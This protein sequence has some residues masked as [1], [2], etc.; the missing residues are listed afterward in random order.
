MGFVVT[1]AAKKLSKLEKKI[2]VIPGGTSAGK[3]YNILPILFSKAA[4]TPNLSISVV[5]ET[6][7][8]LKRGAMRDFLNVIKDTDR[9]HRPFWNK[10]DSLYTLPND[11]FMEFFSADD[12]QRV[13]GPRRDIL[14][15]NEA[16]SLKFD[17]FYQML[18][19]TRK[20]IWLDF[21]PTTEFWAH[22]ELLDHPDAEWLTLTYQD[23]EAL[24]A[25][26]VREIEL[27]RGKAYYN[28]N[29]P[30]PQLFD[31]TNIKNAY[32]HNWWMVYGLGLTGQVQESIYTNW[33]QIDQVPPDA[34]Y[35]GTGL[36]FGFSNDPTAIIDMYLY[37]GLKLFD[38]VIVATGLGISETA[39]ILKRDRKRMVIADRS[40]PLLIEEIKKKGVNIKAYDATDG[41][42][43]KNFG[44]SIMQQ[45]PFLVTKGSL[46]M[47]KEL[48]AYVWEKDKAGKLTGRPVDAND[49]TMDAMRYIGS[50]QKKKRK[51]KKGLVPNYG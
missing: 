37:N 2:K 20:E 51:F 38:E 17:T 49:H 29:L 50:T 27:N 39:E 4:I 44:I 46:N 5:S 28:P 36:D 19:R 40:A 48:R 18:I 41:K 21:N 43:T 34:L 30:I 26:I 11:S 31:K 6:M 14:Y 24:D 45:D 3:T 16:N 13:R 22:E 8:H 42:G 7:P 15:I 32:W 10:T 23:N 47:I 12:E 35:V 1:T 9:Y 33:K 25:S